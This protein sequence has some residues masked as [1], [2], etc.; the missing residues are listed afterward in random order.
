MSGKSRTPVPPI[1]PVR[2]RPTPA[3]LARKAAPAKT[4]R[5]AQPARTAT[6]TAK[7]HAPALSVVKDST[8]APKAAQSVVKDA[9]PAVSEFDWDNLPDVEDVVYTRT[10]VVSFDAEKETPEPIKSRLHASFNKGSYDP[11]S[12]KFQ[13]HYMTQEFGTTVRAEVFVKA[14]KKYCKGKDGDMW[15]FMSKTNGSKVT[16]SVR[17]YTTRERKAK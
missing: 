9:L 2:S 13:G 10:V 7:T 5:A 3:T 1:A 11:K 6:A 15:T 4:I 12:G 14:A 8:E 16:F 17:P